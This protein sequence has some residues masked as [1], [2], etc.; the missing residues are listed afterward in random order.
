MARSFLSNETA[1]LRK[2]FS[3]PNCRTRYTMHACEE[4]AK[5]DMTVADITHIL[6]FGSVTWSEAK[7]DILWHVEGRDID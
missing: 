4:M 1:R 2:L 7:R 6:R 3:S 5:D